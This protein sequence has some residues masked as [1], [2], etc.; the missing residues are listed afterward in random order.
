MISADKDRPKPQIVTQRKMLIAIKSY[1]VQKAL[2][3]DIQPIELT[4]IES[5]L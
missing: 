2:I 1:V 5:Q 3:I 4:I